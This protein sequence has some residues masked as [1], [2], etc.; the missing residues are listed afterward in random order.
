[1]GIASPYNLMCFISSLLNIH[2]QEGF[3]ATRM[4]GF[5][6]ALSP[7]EWVPGCWCG[8]FFQLPFLA[9]FVTLFLP[10]EGLRIW[11]LAEMRH[12]PQQCWP[13]DHDH[14]CQKGFVLQKT[15]QKYLHCPFRYPKAIWNEIKNKNSQVDSY[16]MWGVRKI[17]WRRETPPTPNSG[18][19]NS[20]ECIVP[21]V[22]KNQTKLDD[23]TTTAM[24]S[25][26]LSN[27]ET[28]SICTTVCMFRCS[29]V[30]NSLLPC[31]L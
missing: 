27:R 22:A 5:S 23:W 15:S 30:S 14:I 20:L 28:N 2:C 7:E 25:H 12:L 8:L 16:N 26:H 18:L 10:E 13:G 11:L 4:L 3:G 21:G 6:I 1:M 17:P 24:K 29:F 31:G 19:D 9:Y